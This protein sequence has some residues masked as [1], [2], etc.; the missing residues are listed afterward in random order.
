MSTSKRKVC[1]SLINVTKCNA[2]PCRKEPRH[3]GQGSGPTGRQPAE[4]HQGNVPLVK[5]KILCCN[6]NFFWGVSL[7]CQDASGDLHH[8]FWDNS[9]DSCAISL[10]FFS[11]KG[12]AE[13]FQ[14]KKELT[15]FNTNPERNDLKR[16]SFLCHIFGCPKH[17]LCVWNV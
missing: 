2:Y 17:M 11:L 16:H 8:C 1:L 7:L 13:G 5:V 15:K 10:I 4:W 14:D 6:T 12:K 3:C 9:Q